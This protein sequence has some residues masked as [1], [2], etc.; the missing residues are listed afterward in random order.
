MGPSRIGKPFVVMCACLATATVLRPFPAAAQSQDPGGIVTSIPCRFDGTP[1]APGPACLLAH[2]ELGPLAKARVYWHIDTFPDEASALRA[3]GSFGT[4]VTDYGKVWLFTVEDKEWRPSGGTHV[5]TVGPMELTKAPSFSAEY[6]HS[7]FNPGMSAPIHKHS[8]PEGFYAIEG[9][10]CVE[11]PGGAHT[12]FG[13]G[14]T[15]VMPEGQPMLLMA[16]GKTPRRAFALILHDSKQPS[17]TRIADWKPAGI[18][19]GKRAADATSQAPSARLI[20]DGNV[21][22]TVSRGAP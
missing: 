13:P 15:V 14:N 12:G 6:I 19:Q 11:M 7:F 20:P 17:T 4:V 1:P 21:P 8:G 3:K 22:G 16:I 2:Q 18:C 5:A 9:D 10:T